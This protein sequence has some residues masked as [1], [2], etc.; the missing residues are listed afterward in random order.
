MIIGHYTAYKWAQIL[1]KNAV[2][3]KTPE[4]CTANLKSGLVKFDFG[5]SLLFPLVPKV[6]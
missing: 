1:P 6:A 2:N 4:E 5:R 3:T